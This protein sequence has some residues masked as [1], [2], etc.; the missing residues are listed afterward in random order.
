MAKFR[1]ES[2][3]DPITGNYFNELYYPEGAPIPMATSAP[4]Y[5]SLQEAEN[6]VVDLLK[7]AMPGQPVRVVDST[8][9]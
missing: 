3:L 7:R 2:V 1:V 9:I 5:S 6:E 8:K 4:L